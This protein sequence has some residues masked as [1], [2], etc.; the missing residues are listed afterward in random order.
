MQTDVQAYYLRTGCNGG[1]SLLLVA[2]HRQVIS[3]T[4]KGSQNILIDNF[5]ITGVYSQ[6]GSHG[7]GIYSRAFALVWRSH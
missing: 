5:I 7:G 3:R 1:A 6:D 4:S 2:G